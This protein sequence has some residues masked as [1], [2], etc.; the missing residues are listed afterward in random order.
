MFCWKLK[1]SLC[2]SVFIMKPK[3]KARMNSLMQSSEVLQENSVKE[4][5]LE[6]FSIDSIG[7]CGFD[8]AANLYRIC[9]MAIEGEG[10]QL[11]AKWRLSFDPSAKVKDCSNFPMGVNQFGTVMYQVTQA[12]KRELLHLLTVAQELR[13]SLANSGFLPWVEH[14]EE[15]QDPNLKETCE[16]FFSPL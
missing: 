14:E 16:E 4:E 10:L 12:D 8:Q 15:W 2:E 3:S 6:F 11:P 7:L 13:T 1:V 9:R 5:K